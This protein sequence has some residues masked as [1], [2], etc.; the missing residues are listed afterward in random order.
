MRQVVQVPR[1]LLCGFEGS[2]RK[3]DRGNVWAHLEQHLEAMMVPG[4]KWT[5]TNRERKRE[6]NVMCTGVYVS[7]CGYISHKARDNGVL[8]TNQNLGPAR[9]PN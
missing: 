6:R 4:V 2:L 9:D 3:E 7:E 1:L 5:G 8:S